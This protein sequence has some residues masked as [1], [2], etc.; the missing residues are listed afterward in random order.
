MPNYRRALIPGGTWFF[1]MN[2]LERKNNDLL[3]REIDL[4]RDTV[5]AVRKRHPFQ[6]DAWVVLPEHLHAVWT[7]PPGDA[8]FSKRWR[9]IKSGFSRAL[10]KTEYRTNV[11]KMAGERGIYPKGTSGSGIFGSIAYE[12]KQISNG[13]SIMYMLIRLNMVWSRGPLTGRIPVFIG[14]LKEVSIRKIGVAI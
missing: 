12:T 1:T 2:L 14:M 13:M 4:L 11:R 3:I 7:L 10:P 8:D 5:R 6:I 9:L